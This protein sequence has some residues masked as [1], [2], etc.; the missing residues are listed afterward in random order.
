MQ[1]QKFKNWGWAEYLHLDV[2][3]QFG[4]VEQ[5]VADDETRSQTSVAELQKVEESL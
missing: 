5:R 3:E 1:N 4:E 2:D